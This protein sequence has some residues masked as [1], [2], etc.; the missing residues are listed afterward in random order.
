MRRELVDEAER[1]DASGAEQAEAGA[2][3]AEAAEAGEAGEEVI[4]ELERALT[5]AFG[6]VTRWWTGELP[7]VGVMRLPLP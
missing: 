2:A 4:D 3:S 1:S 5:G 6:Q 7:D